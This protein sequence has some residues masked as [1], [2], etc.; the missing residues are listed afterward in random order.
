MNRTPRHAALIAALL[1]GFAVQAFSQNVSV[2]R[3]S[4]TP[5]LGGMLGAPGV[6]PG[7]VGSPLST[8][9]TPMLSLTP[10]LSVIPAPSIAPQA[11]PAMVDAAPVALSVTPVAL[12]AA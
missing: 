11:I 1:V 9:L 2:P 3:V 6:V 8:T 5:T 7:A 4:L 10:T 12:S